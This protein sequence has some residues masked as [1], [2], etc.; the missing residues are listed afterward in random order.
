MADDPDL[1]EQRESVELRSWVV[2]G[3][4]LG[5]ALFL[6]LSAAG[7]Y[8]YFTLSGGQ[9]FGPPVSQFPPPGLQSNPPGDLR[10]FRARQ[11]AELESYGWADREHGLVR[12]PIQRAMQI[13]AGRG[14]EAYAPLQS[15][16]GTPLQVRPEAR[17]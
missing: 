14:T 1:A 3:V 11:Q 15:P 9:Q 13:I 2:L 12:I 6:G 7:I 8:T 17:R 4:G 5:T 10:A 16:P